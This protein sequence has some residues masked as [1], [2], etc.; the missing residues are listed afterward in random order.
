MKQ[1]MKFLPY[2]TVVVYSI[3]ITSLRNTFL[4]LFKLFF[5]LNKDKATNVP[6]LNMS[7]GFVR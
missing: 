6:T 1:I 3:Y 2:V 4:S 7:V 5:Q